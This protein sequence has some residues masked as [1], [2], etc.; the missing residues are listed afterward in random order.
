MRTIRT[1]YHGVLDYSGAVISRL[2]PNL[3]GFAQV[4]AMMTKQNASMRAMA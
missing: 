1:F 2:S 4:G 3:F